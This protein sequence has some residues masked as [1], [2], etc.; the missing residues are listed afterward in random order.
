MSAERRALSTRAK[1]L[2]VV[3]ALVAVGLVAGTALVLPKQLENR[4]TKLAL[5][6]LAR[7]H[8]ANP[9]AWSAAAQRAHSFRGAW[10]GTETAF[11]F[12]A[13]EEDARLYLSNEFTGIG[14]HGWGLGWPTDAW[15]QPIRYR[16]PGPV[17]KRGWDLWSV[18]PN[19]VDDEGRGDDVVLGEDADGVA[20][21]GSR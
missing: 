16:S 21:V 1:L 11:V 8:D 6:K 3:G 4:A 12:L 10:S 9:T 17:H 13:A 14:K 2:I 5:G 15:R 19:G 20:V 7:L 18:G